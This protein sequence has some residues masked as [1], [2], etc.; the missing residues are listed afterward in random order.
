MSMDMMMEWGL[1]MMKRMQESDG[2][3]GKKKRRLDG[4]D[5]NDEEEELVAVSFNIV[6][7][8]DGQ[9]RIC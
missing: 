5:D 3:L 8:D 2:K 1:N 9:T 6:G 7:E 4:V